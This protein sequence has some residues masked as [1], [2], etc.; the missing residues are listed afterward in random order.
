MSMDFNRCGYY[1]FAATGDLCY[2]YSLYKTAL[3]GG[4]DYL[5][6]ECK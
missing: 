5:C 6:S 4:N 3:T 2:I 1:N